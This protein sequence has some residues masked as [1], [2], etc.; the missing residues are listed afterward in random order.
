VGD[1]GVSEEF[2][3]GG[4]PSRY[5]TRTLAEWQ[6]ILA[7]WENHILKGGPSPKSNIAAPAD[8]A[9]ADKNIR[10]KGMKEDAVPADTQDKKAAR[11]DRKAA[12]KK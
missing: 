1:P 9:S 2:R 10:K 6:Q 12:G 8:M 7:M 4:W 11:K 5:P 3:Q